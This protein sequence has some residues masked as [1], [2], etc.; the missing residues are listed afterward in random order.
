MWGVCQVVHKACGRSQY[1]IKH[2]INV[3]IR[4]VAVTMQKQNKLGRLPHSEYF[5][6]EVD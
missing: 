4:L 1:K 6:P 2:S 3:K 5:F